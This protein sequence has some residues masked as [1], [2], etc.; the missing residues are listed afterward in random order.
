M[1][2]IF[3]KTVVWCEDIFEG[4]LWVGGVNVSPFLALICDHKHRYYIYPHVVSC[5]GRKMERRLKIQ[6]GGTFWRL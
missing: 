5:I 3:Y 4:A 2:E 1:G 6:H